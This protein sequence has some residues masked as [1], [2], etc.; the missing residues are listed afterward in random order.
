MISQTL[1]CLILSL[2]SAAL[3]G[4]GNPKVYP[5]NKS[6]RSTCQNLTTEYLDSRMKRCCSKCP[7]GT[8][9]LQLC[10]E[11]SDTLCGECG[12]YQYTAFWNRL[13]KCIA[14]EAPCSAGMSWKSATST[15]DSSGSPIGL[16]AL[17]FRGNHLEGE[18]SFCWGM[19]WWT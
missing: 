18:G 16:S 11:T 10:T 9:I 12:L 17:S 6:I 19:S 15:R 13:K 2:S 5:P 1:L 3:P 7:P 4:I 8:R 14:C